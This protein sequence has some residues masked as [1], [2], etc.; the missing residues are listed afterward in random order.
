MDINFMINKFKWLTCTIFFIFLYLL[1]ITPFSHAQREQDFQTWLIKFRKSAVS[2][3]ISKETLDL[4]LPKVQF[5]PRVIELDKSQPE[6]RMTVEEYLDRIVTEIRVLKGR[7]IMEQN[8]DLLN[9]IHEQ[10]GVQPSV[11]L[12]LWGIETDF[13]RNI[14][15]YSVIDAVATLAYQGRRAAFFRQEFLQAL[16]I[17]DNGHIL[18]EQM[19]GSWAGA[20]GQIQ[21]MPTS[22]RS[23]A[24]DHDGDGKRDIWN[25]PP[26]VFASAANYLSKNGWLKDGIWGMKAAIPANFKLSIAGLEVRKRLSEWDSLGVQYADKVESPSDHSQLWSVVA[27]DMQKKTAY[28]VNS[29]Y[30][31]ILRWNRSNHF[32]IAVGTLSDRIAG[33]Q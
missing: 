13:G 9:G 24:V 21:F 10:Y 28:L 12:A 8:Q 16:R 30:L 22:F 25:S 23:F 4:T 2:A 32:A 33:K 18:P 26:D 1:I 20:M 14:G 6:F 29:N 7:E 19:I 31:A 3:G 11:I 5:I 27:P 15:S 17:I